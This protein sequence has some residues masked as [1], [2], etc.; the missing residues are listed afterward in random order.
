[1]SS[2]ETSVIEY[3]ETTQKQPRRSKARQS[4]PQKIMVQPTT[5]IEYVDVEEQQRGRRVPQ[6]PQYEIVEEVSDRSTSASPVQEM[7][8]VVDASRHKRHRGRKKEKKHGFR[9]VS[10]KHLKSSH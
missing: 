2:P 6:K 4:Q 8:E 7:V 1:M 3:V 10:I 9:K 5:H